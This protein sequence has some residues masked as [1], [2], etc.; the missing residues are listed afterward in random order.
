M[1]E[2]IAIVAH[3]AGG[4]EILASYVHRLPLQEQRHCLLSLGGPAA[5]VFAR[6]LPQ[7]RAVPLEQ[8]IGEADRV[9]GGSGWQS[10][11]EL[12]AIALASSTSQP[13]RHR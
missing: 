1:S 12:R 5:G 6:R 2:R 11:L 13:S 3:D 10:D 4:A 9:L 7:I 8:A